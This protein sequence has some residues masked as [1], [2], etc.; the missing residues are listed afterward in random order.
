MNNLFLSSSAIVL[1]SFVNEFLKSIFL[2]RPAVG[3][4]KFMILTGRPLQM[5]PK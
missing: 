2:G 5:A 1:K 4:G 3:G